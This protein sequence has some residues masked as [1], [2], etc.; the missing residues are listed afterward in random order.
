M[1]K[2]VLLPLATGA[3]ILVTLVANIWMAWLHL[4]AGEPVQIIT[5][6]AI[7]ICPVG[8][9]G[10]F[11]VASRIAKRAHHCEAAK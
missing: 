10:N 9:V 6:A 1:N 8:V 3:F 4:R 11:W 2:Q 7:G 5:W